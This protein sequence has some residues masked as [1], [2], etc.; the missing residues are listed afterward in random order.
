MVNPDEI[1]DFLLN[2]TRAETARPWAIEWLAKQ[3]L[4]ISD[5]TMYFSLGVTDQWPWPPGHQPQSTLGEEMSSSP[6]LDEIVDI[7]VHEEEEEPLTLDLACQILVDK[8]SP[9]D[10]PSLCAFFLRWR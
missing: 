9:K 5:P 8:I 4:Y 7:T 1:E 3:A 2:P 6:A 10:I